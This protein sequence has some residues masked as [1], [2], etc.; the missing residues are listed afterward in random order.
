MKH[1]GAQTLAQLEPLLVKLRAVA[2]LVERKPGT[3]YLR[4]SAFLHFHEDPDGMFADVKLHGSSFERLPLRTPQDHALLVE[5][6]AA[7]V[8]SRLKRATPP[9]AYE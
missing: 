2:G 4:S 6:V 5:A 1:A 7:A 3:F 8:E 9:E